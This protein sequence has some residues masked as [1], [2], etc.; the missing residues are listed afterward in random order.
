[1]ACE[2]ALFG[3][4]GPPTR[5]SRSCGICWRAPANTRAARR[6]ACAESCCRRAARLR[7]MAFRSTPACSSDERQDRRR[8]CVRGPRA[9]RDSSVLVASLMHATCAARETPSSTDLA[10]NP[11]GPIRRAG[12]SAA[13]IASRSLH[14]RPCARPAARASGARSCD[15]RCGRRRNRD[16]RR[17]PA[18][19]VPQPPVSR[20]ASCMRAL[21]PTAAAGSTAESSAAAA[22][23]PR[24]CRRRPRQRLHQHVADEIH[25]V[26]AFFAIVADDAD[27]KGCHWLVRA[28]DKPHLCGEPRTE[29][30]ERA[31]DD[32]LEHELPAQTI[33]Q[34]PPVEAF[35]IVGRPA[36][37]VEDRPHQM[38]AVAGEHAP[39]RA[40]DQVY[41]RR[42]WIVADL[43]PAGDSCARSASRAPAVRFRPAR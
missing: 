15:R 34:H 39:I 26:P 19:I 43:P 25:A 31:G 32:A 38:L 21:C 29:P 11:S 24:P 17:E 42:A 12:G 22:A 27:A 9:A 20:S 8:W 18:R 13:V 1:M 2:I 6:S 41:G 35:V 7:S 3:V 40:R 14:V 30:R 36:A 37:G 5:T 33:A 16:A 4:S 23:R 10:S 28:A